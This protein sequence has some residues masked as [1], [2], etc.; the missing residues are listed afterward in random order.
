MSRI[1]DGIESPARFK[2]TPDKR[3]LQSRKRDKR[4]NP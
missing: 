1:L 2:K 4:P 3:S